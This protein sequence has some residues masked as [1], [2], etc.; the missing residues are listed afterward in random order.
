MEENKVVAWSRK[1]NMYLVH[2]MRST[3]VKSY[4]YMLKRDQSTVR[5]TLSSAQRCGN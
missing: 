4:R 1:Y 2:E 5:A 3:D